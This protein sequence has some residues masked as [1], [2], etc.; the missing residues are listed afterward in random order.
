MTRFDFTPLYRSTIGFDR[1]AGLMEAA[2]ADSPRDTHAPA[3]D[4]IQADEN[5]YRLNLAVA[6]YGFDDLTVEQQDQRLV[7]TA[8]AADEAEGRQFLHQGIARRG[9]RRE[10]ALAEHVKVTG[11]NLVHGLLTIDLVRELPEEKKPRSIE[12]RTSAPESLGGRLLGKARKLLSDGT[13]NSKA[14]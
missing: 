2:L 4:I 7:I 12:I 3:Y 11:A 8:R 5:S 13:G 14:A 9:F 10:F 1:L 6:G